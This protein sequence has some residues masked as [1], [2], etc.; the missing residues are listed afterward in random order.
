VLSEELLF[1]TI[2]STLSGFGIYYVN[3]DNFTIIL[4]C[5]IN[6]RCTLPQ[7]ISKT[8][9]SYLSRISLLIYLWYYILLDEEYSIQQNE[10]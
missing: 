5:K 8:L 6:G 9:Y 1:T 7:P 10:P 3:S 2:T 4:L